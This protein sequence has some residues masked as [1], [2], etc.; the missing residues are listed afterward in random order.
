MIPRKK[1]ILRVLAIA[2]LFALNY[3]FAQNTITL[4]LNNADIIDLVNWAQELTEKTIVLHP[5]VKGQ[6]TVV[7]G[8]PMTPGEAYQVFLSVLEIHGFTAVESEKLIKI[9][10]TNLAKQSSAPVYNSLDSQPPQE[11]VVRVLKIQNVAASQLI[12]IIKPLLPQEAYIAAY[13]ATNSIVLADKVG[14]IRQIVKLIENIDQ[15]GVLEIDLIEIQFASAQEVISILKTLLPGNQTGDT[16][17]LRLAADERSNSI[18]VTGDAATRSQLRK[19]IHKLDRPLAGDGNTHV[20]YLNYASAQ[21]LVPVLQGVSGSEQNNEK[22]QSINNSDINII[23]NE[24]L[25]AL[26]IT[27]PPSILKTMKG[28]IKKMDVRRPQVLVE[29]LIVEVSENL[30]SQFGVEWQVP[31]S[32]DEQV[33]GGF[34]SFPPEVSPIRIGE[35]GNMILGTGLSL[36]YL[37]GGTTLSAVIAALKGTANA[38]ILSTPTIMAL[39]NEQARILVGENVPFV[40]GSEKRQGDSNPFQTIERQDIGVSLS[41][42]PR[43]NNDNSVTL[44][45]EQK[46]ESIS[47]T[48]VETADIVTN[49]REI[50]T[51]VLINDDDILVLG[52]LIRDEAIETESRVPFLGSIPLIGRAFRSTTTSKVKR[53][54]MV[55]IHPKILRSADQSSEISRT[56]YDYMTEKQKQSGFVEEP[57]LF[58]KHQPLL[59]PLENE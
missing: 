54:L 17:S 12:N 28:V 24:S 50:T 23:A 21:E 52:G 26:I 22:D 7:A 48:D 49:K 27:A 32:S 15:V 46:V 3:A 45:I 30:S 29:A 36:G 51:R 2:Y 8:D 6:V 16:T 38:N 10:P 41:I 37:R 58:P 34:S 9:I 11:V 18:L 56:K 13:P 44:D 53:N 35:L 59:P 25:N 42:L 55:F 14:N 20:V 57:F 39:D 33:I 47:R 43:V 40:T 4:T 1:I 19:L 5:S 31:P